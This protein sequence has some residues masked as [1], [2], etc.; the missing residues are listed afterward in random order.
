MNGKKFWTWTLF[1]NGHTVQGN[2]WAVD[3][4]DAASRALCSNG[5]SGKLVGDEYA[6]P[7][8]CIQDF[9]AN[10]QTDFELREEGF[11]LRVKAA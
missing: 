2:V 3:P 11:S 5:Q 6:I 8:E 7:V 4:R 10:D 1:T 9:P